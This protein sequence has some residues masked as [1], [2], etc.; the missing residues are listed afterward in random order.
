LAHY[1][2]CLN[3]D[4]STKFYVEQVIVADQNFIDTQPGK[5]VQTSY[6]TK[7]N[8]HYGAN[9]EPDGGVALRGNYAGIGYTYDIQ[10]DVFY[11]PQPFASWILN[12]STWLWEAPVP[13]PNDGK[14]YQWDEATQSWVEVVVA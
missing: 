4:N 3:I 2:K 11:A 1:A 10:N 7:G 6:N 9:G 8:V 5:W 14:A 12:T 13:Y